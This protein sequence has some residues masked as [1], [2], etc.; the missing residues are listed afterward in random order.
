MFQY[1]NNLNNRKFL[2]LFRLLNTNVDQSVNTYNDKLR[3][4]ESSFPAIK[5]ANFNYDR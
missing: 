2:R 5:A 3:L 1:F 4:K